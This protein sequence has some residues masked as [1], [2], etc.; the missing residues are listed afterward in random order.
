LKAP[1]ER[2]RASACTRAEDLEVDQLFR[3]RQ[4]IADFRQ[5]GI[6]LIQIEKIPPTEPSR[7][8]SRHLPDW[9]SPPAIARVFFEAF[10]WEAKVP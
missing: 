9:I 1:S 2:F 8:S 6:P 4:S 3:S 10:E 5:F 7:F